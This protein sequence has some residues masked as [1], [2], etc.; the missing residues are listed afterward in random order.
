M[1]RLLPGK[2]PDPPREYDYSS[3]DQI[4]K[5]IQQVLKV[6]VETQID[7]EDREALDFFLSK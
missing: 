6:P 1:A 3:F 7:A 2:L 5:R 4:I